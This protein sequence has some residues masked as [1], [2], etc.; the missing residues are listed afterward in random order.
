MPSNAFQAVEQAPNGTPGQ[1][2]PGW[3]DS[4]TLMK[5]GYRSKDKLASNP[6]TPSGRQLIEDYF[7]KDAER[8]RD[9]SR[10]MMNLLEKKLL[11]TN[12]Q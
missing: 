6:V 3:F 8:R 1:G 7:E 9:P 2:K 11:H 4:S 12:V 5:A 10:E